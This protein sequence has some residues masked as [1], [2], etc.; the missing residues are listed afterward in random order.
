MII[1]IKVGTNTV[2]HEDTVD[3]ASVTARELFEKWDVDYQGKQ[4][5]MN[6]D[7]IMGD[8][9]DKTLDELGVEIDPSKVNFLA[10]VAKHDNAR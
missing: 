8:D 5:N 7:T 6:G 4:A 1:K 10:C 2:R 9:L 3:T